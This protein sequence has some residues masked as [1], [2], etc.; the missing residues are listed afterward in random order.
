MN[1][2]HS[3]TGL[4]AAT[5]PPRPE[6]SP[7]RYKLCPVCGCCGLSIVLVLKLGINLL[8]ITPFKESGPDTLRKL[9]CWKYN[10]EKSLKTS[11]EERSIEYV[12]PTRLNERR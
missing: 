6:T 8:V 11:M 4:T 9:S 2:F 5:F 7:P 12:R 10:R 3:M 1:C